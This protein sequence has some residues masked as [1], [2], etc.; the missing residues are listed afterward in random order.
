MILNC[1][2]ALSLMKCPHEAFNRYHRNLNGPT[3]TSLLDGGAVHSIIAKGLATRDWDY[4]LEAGHKEFL[5]SVEVSTIPPEEAFTIEANW[6]L[7]SAMTMIF[8]AEYENEG[9]QVLQPECE[10]DLPLP[11]SEHSCVWLHWLDKQGGEHFSPPGVEDILNGNVRDPH[12]GGGREACHCWQP[13][14]FVGRADAIMLWNG[15]PCLHE[16]KPTRIK[17]ELFWDAFELDLQITAYMYGV[18]RATGLR[19]RSAVVAALFR[20]SEKQVAN[21]N[22]MRKFGQAKTVKD[23]LG[24]ERRVFMRTQEDL[25]RV[26]HTLV[27]LCQEWEWRILNNQFRMSPTKNTC[28]SYGR[29]C[30]FHACCMSHDDPTEL[31]LMFNRL[32]QG[33]REQKHNYVDVKL[34][35]LCNTT[36]R[37]YIAF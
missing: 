14:R 37:G 3:T 15:I 6:E 23:Y 19:P 27:Q 26:E 9:Y 16:Y 21:W 33:W 8:K 28:I 7:V 13:H 4:A 36:E 31:G 20:P 22:Q 2:R 24:Y 5:K 17:G 1:S 10:F 25:A 12:E 11:G 18:E 30:D 35:Q 32:P 29:R 34:E